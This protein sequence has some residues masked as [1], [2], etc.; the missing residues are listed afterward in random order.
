MA[1]DRQES[2][3]SI[4]PGAWFIGGTSQPP[5][6]PPPG[7][8]A[9]PT[10]QTPG[11]PQ[12]VQAVSTNPTPLAT[13]EDQLL[14]GFRVL[15][16]TRELGVFCTKL[17][18]D[19]GAEVI[20]I[21]PPTGDP[22]RQRGP[23]FKDVPHPEHSLYFM[24]YNTGKRSITLDLEQPE[25]QALFKKLVARADV[26]VEGFAPGYMDR[27][28]LGYEQLR[29]INPGIV[30]AAVSPFGQTGPY[31]D[32]KASDLVLMGMSGWMQITGEPEW[33][34]TR[35]GNEQSHFP[36]AQY[37][38]LGIVAALY[39]RE[40]ASGEGQYIEVSAMEALL[41]YYTENHPAVAWLLSQ[42]N[43][44]RPG[45]R[46]RMT[47]PMGV[48][49]CQD[50]WIAL[51]VVSAGEW[52]SLAQWMVEATGDDAILDDK[53]KGGTHARQAYYD[54]IIAYV[55]G[56]LAGLTRQEL[57]TEGQKRNLA[58]LPVATVED[59]LNDPH[60]AVGDFWI[61]LDHPVVGKLK[62]PRGAFDTDIIHPP[63]KAAPLVGEDNEAIYC[64]ELG[65]S[66]TELGAL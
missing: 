8:P 14:S 45:V 6:P 33:P 46:S 41:T 37:A 42:T 5:A 64:H 26:V 4:T 13:D 34:P 20:R 58:V 56:F 59:M 47:V 2:W 11:T 49:P 18:A 9:T 3:R 51:G 66:A 1:T 21:E 35:Q 10:Q 7:A 61:E 44:G 65:L 32:Y 36:G 53:Y 50:G 63:R 24:Y 31:K 62:Y 19:L 60:L 54:E 30:M 48:F 39:N 12:P 23:F 17:L 29:S 25:G 27:I 40:L 38:A 43:V 55:I 15:D 16:L 22:L 52:E 57:F 28:G